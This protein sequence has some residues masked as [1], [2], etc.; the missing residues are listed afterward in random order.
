MKRAALQETF[1][2]RVKSV[3]S[4]KFPYLRLPAP[5]GDWSGYD[6]ALGNEFPEVVGSSGGW[7][8]GPPVQFPQTVYSPP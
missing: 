6:D 2:A 8:R 1:D 7:S 3:K 5:R 4:R